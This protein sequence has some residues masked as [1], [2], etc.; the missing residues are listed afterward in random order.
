MGPWLVSVDEIPDPQLLDISLRV[1]GVVKQHSNTREQI[2]PVAQVIADLSRYLMLDPG[3]I[4][5]TG[6]PSGV[7]NARKPP[8]Y[9]HPGDVV[10]AEIQSIGVL[11]TPIIGPNR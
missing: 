8:E 9:L 5:I 7:G 2:F 4:V 1:N 3:D 11:R 10:E 6:T